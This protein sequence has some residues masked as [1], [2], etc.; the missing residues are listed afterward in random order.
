MSK[1][2]LPRRMTPRIIALALA[3]ALSAC[4]FNPDRSPVVLEL[5]AG[6]EV[7]QVDPQWW[8]L[9]GDPALT[10]LVAL[11]RARNADVQLA[12]SRIEEARAALGIASAEQLPRLDLGASGARQRVSQNGT[13]RGLSPN[14][15]D[16]YEFAANASW[17]ID[18]WG[19]VR[20]QRE[21]AVEQLRAT[22]LGSA[23][24]LLSVSAATAEAYFNLRALD[25]QV[26][27]A[28]QTLA[29]REDSYQLRQKRFKGGM[30]SELDVRQAEA[31]LMDARAALPQLQSSQAQAETA[32]I[33]LTGASPKEVYGSAAERGPRISA[34]LPGATGLPAS[35]PSDL[36]LRRPDIQSAEAILQA[37]RANVQVARAG[38]FPRITLTGLFGVQSVEFGDLFKGPSRVW[39]YAGNLAMPLFDNG[40]TASQVDQARAQEKQALISYEQAVRQSFGDVRIAF[41]EIAHS[42]ERADALAQ[43][44]V[45]LTRQVTLSQLRYDNGYSSYLEVLDAERSQFS[46]QLQLVSAQRDQLISQLTL[47]KALGGGWRVDLANTAAK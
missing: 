7:A 15:Y 30:T 16:S 11:A 43:Q 12:L 25:D 1:R 21:A 41:S 32:L 37:R 18:L 8:L 33:I 13:Q 20:N 22:E 14:P 19:R 28:R 9:F 4:A 24:T 47:I 35:L 10:R 39:S 6:S 23:T 27:I 40:L 3:A 34:T 5:P 2:L 44:T 38:Y 17:E 29:S 36:L 31:E 46:A 26:E 45:A 42:R